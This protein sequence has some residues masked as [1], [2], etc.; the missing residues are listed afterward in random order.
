[1]KILITSVIDLRRSAH[2]RLHE[3]IRYLSR[4]HDITAVSPCDWW[5]AK[6]VE[7]QQYSD[8]FEDGFSSVTIKYCTSKKIRP[9]FQELISPIVLGNILGNVNY[10]SFDVH[11]NYNSLIAGYYVT[12]KCKSAG[13][14][15]VYDIADD[16]PAMVRHSPQMPSL[17]RPLAVFVS[18]TVL[19][20]NVKLASKI[21]IINSTLSQSLRIPYHRTKLIPNGVDTELFKYDP[22]G[23]L[24]AE[25]GLDNAFVLGYVGVLREWVDLNS[26]FSVVRA[27]NTAKK[28]V[29]VLVVGEEGGLIRNQAMAREQGVQDSIVFTGTVPYQLIPRYISCMDACLIPFKD[30]AVAQNSL[31]LKIFEYMACERPVIS[32][33][34]PGIKS[35]FGDKVL[36]ADDSE[37]LRDRILELFD[38]EALRKSLGK[39]GCK[40]VIQNYSWDTI[41]SRLEEVL[42]EVASEKKQ[43][44]L[45]S[46]QL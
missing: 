11:F 44:K 21:T 31:P 20:N 24:K 30:N 15:T 18:S 14:K 42:L 32:S 12:K 38:N 45:K 37:D 10:R 7:N 23:D 29:K 8:S 40:L 39:E 3:F 6:Q 1:M 35:A 13:I 33:K 19:K 2:N 28:K 22:C 36:Y 41:C 25:L 34:I 43:R 26:V 16:L 46:K 9:I 17:L 5:K 4:R 27:L